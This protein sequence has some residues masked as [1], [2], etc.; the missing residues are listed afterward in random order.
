MKFS[1]FSDMN[2]RLADL[3][4]RNERFGD[5]P[6]NP[7]TT[8]RESKDLTFAQLARLSHV[9]AMAIKRAEFGTYSFPLPSLVDY[10]VNSGAITESVLNNAYSD[11]VDLQR[12]RHRHYFG[13]TLTVNTSGEHPFRQLRERRPSL[14][15]SLPLPVGLLEV[16]K[17][18]C[19]PLDTIQ[20]F[21][22]RIQ[23]QTVPKP[24]KAA[25]NQIG[26]SGNAIAAFELDF[27]EWRK[28]KVTNQVTFV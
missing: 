15:T 13:P 14:A 20:F 26:Y 5:A 24:I 10:W 12:L 7:F 23:Q 18:L 19:I 21:E 28:N 22:R 16:S 4:V 27:I 2:N 1:T 6:E 3:R 8:L 11:F 9:D 25:L 17:A